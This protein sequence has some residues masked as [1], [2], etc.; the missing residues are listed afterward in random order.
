MRKAIV[1]GLLLCLL[2]ST[3]ALAEPTEFVY[4]DGITFGMSIDRV[5]ELLGE[6]SDADS[7]TLVYGGLTVAGENATVSYHFSDGLLYGILVSFTDMYSNANKHITKFFSIDD[8]LGE[9]YG[10]PSISG[11]YKWSDSLFKDDEEKY[12]IAV[13]AGYLTI[14]SQWVVN[15]VAISHTLVGGEGKIN[16]LILYMPVGTQIEKDTS[17]L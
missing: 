5:A 9:K 4:G 13:S 3:L 1:V 7:E 12:G 2:S 16:N 8:S 15:E 14:F 17:G 10:T 6:A 11:K